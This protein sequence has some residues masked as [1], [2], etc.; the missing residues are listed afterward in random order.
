MII[1]GKYLSH[2]FFLLQLFI[3]LLFFHIFNNNEQKSTTYITN[4]GNPDQMVG[5]FFVHKLNKT[6]IY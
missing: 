1:I 4:D 6:K 3:L 2:N 5:I